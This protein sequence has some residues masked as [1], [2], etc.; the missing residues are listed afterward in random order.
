MLC[1]VYLEKKL[2]KIILGHTSPK[3]ALFGFTP[4]TPCGK[5]SAFIVLF[6]GLLQQTDRI[7]NL[8]FLEVEFF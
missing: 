3:I 7:F 6:F 2:K 5:T 8:S 4:C 1:C